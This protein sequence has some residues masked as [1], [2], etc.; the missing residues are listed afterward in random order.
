MPMFTTMPSTESICDD[1]LELI[2]FVN[3]INLD[4]LALTEH[5]AEGITIKIKYI[6]IP[7]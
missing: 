6:F 5:S 1:H 2:A 4:S 7:H 3:I